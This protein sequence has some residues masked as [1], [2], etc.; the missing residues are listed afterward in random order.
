MRF[1][2]ELIGFS[3]W[4]DYLKSAPAEWREVIRAKVEYLTDRLYDKVQE[5]LNGGV[6]NR[7]SGQLAESIRRRVE[8]S[9]RTVSGWVGPQEDTKKALTQELGGRGYYEIVATNKNMLRFFWEKH[10]IMFVGKRVW[11]PPA[12]A[13][14][15]LLNA[16]EEM[17]GEINAE[18]EELVDEMTK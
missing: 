10:G 18:L 13:R 4:G 16:L 11:H 17:E 3:E 14:Y 7:K 12:E 2:V 6:I 1:G 8:V 9:E 5:N 15:Y